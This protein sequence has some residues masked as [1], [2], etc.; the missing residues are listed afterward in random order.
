[1]EAL[2]MIYLP[3]TIISFLQAIGYM[4]ITPVFKTLFYIDLKFRKG[5][6]NS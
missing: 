4:L 3:L 1:M 5:E 6:L 2:R